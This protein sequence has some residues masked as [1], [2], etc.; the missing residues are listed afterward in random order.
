MENTLDLKK[1]I[2]YVNYINDNI[3]S[4]LF[5]FKLDTYMEKYIKKFATNIDLLN[6][7]TLDL[8]KFKLIIIN[9]ISVLPKMTKLSQDII[10]EKTKNI[11]KQKNVALLLH[12]L[13][14]YSISY[15]T[16]KYNIVIDEKKQKKYIP[17][18]T[19]TPGKKEFL[20]LF[21][22]Y[23][24][25]YLISIYDCPEFD[26]FYKYYKNIKKFFIINHGFDRKIF[27]PMN[28]EKKYDILFYGCEK[29]EIYPLRVR[30]LNLCQKM[31]LVV[32]KLNYVTG[33]KNS[34]EKQSEEVLCRYINESWLSIA[35]VSNF[36]YFV[37]KY[38]EISACNCL[39]L[40]DINLQGEQI[41]KENI[42]KISDDMTDQEIMDKIN[43][44]LNNKNLI[45]EKINNNHINLKKYTY[46]HV[47]KK[48]KKI[49]QSI[50]NNSDCPH[51]YKNFKNSLKTN[52][53]NKINAHK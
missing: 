37:R 25:K 38:L 50:I 11:K 21:N 3:V 45:K 24:V 26:F 17:N 36:S 33:D 47:V 14:D 23:N 52:K 46:R 5:A 15:S 4:E 12:D 49:S 41:L 43:Y 18:L 28:I 51:E 9:M 39:V 22:Q 6:L 42:V 20:K 10:N 32:K 13:H 8:S 27:Y 35:C 16:F 34:K 2:L 44:F 7:D 30:L 29:K 53:I 1:D 19:E 48:I 40:G 31:N